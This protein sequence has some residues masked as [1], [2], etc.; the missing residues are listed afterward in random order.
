MR[1]ETKRRGREVPLRFVRQATSD[2]R[3]CKCPG[4]RD[5]KREKGLV[6]HGCLH[7]RIQQDARNVQRL[8]LHHL[9]APRT[10]TTSS[11]GSPVLCALIFQR[12]VGCQTKL[13]PSLTF[14]FMLWCG[15][16]AAFT[17]RGGSSSQRSLPFCSHIIVHGQERIKGDRP[18]KLLHYEFFVHCSLALVQGSRVWYTAAVKGSARKMHHLS[19]GLQS[20][21]AHDSHSV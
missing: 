12:H 5:G 1:K 3:A 4:G 9:I 13:F 20:A 2:L 16:R 14:I 15:T 18:Y 11:I 8:W 7:Q 6:P 21:G 19:F 17:C 10:Q